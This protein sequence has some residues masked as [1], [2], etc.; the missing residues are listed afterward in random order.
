[1]TNPEPAHLRGR[2]LYSA[3]IEDDLKQFHK[4][5]GLGLTDEQIAFRMATTVEEVGKWRDLSSVTSSQSRATRTA[6]GAGSAAPRKRR[7]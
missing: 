4:L 7:K 5:D 3:A 6:N 1:M 2:R